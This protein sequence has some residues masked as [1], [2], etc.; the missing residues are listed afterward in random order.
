MVK[1]IGLLV[2]AIALLLTQLGEAIP[3]RPRVISNGRGS[4]ATVTIPT[5]LNMS[6]I[7][8]LG[9]VFGG[10]SN[11]L[12]VDTPVTTG[13]PFGSQT[14]FPA[15][16]SPTDT[17]W[18][19]P[20]IHE[21]TT[22]ATGG[23]LTNVE[24][25]V[26][27]A[28]TELH[29]LGGRSW[30]GHNRSCSGCSA[31]DIQKGSL[32]QNVY[33]YAYEANG[34]VRRAF[35]ARQTAGRPYLVA[36]NVLIH[37]EADDDA[38]LQAVYP[39]FLRQYQQDANNDSYLR[40]AQTFQVPLFVTQMNACSVG[41]GGAASSNAYMALQ[42][43]ANAYA[44]SGSYVMCGQRMHFG[45]QATSLY[46]ADGIHLSAQGQR[47]HGEALGL[48]L[49]SVLEA[50]VIFR[51]LLPSY[52]DVTATGIDVDYTGNIPCLNLNSTNT[53]TTAC[54]ASNCC[55]GAPLVL[56]TTI[57][58]LPWD[59]DQTNTPTY[60]F[61][62]ECPALTVRRPWITNVAISNSTHVAI[63]TNRPIPPGCTLSY[64]RYSVP[65]S[66]GG[67]GTTAN[68]F[69][70]ARG[71]LRDSMNI[72]G[73]L[74]GQRIYTIGP[75]WTAT[76]ASSGPDLSSI[77]TLL[78]DHD[79][80]Y[81]WD[82]PSGTSG[83]TLVNVTGASTY[84]LPA[85]AGRSWAASSPGAGIVPSTYG[86]ITPA[87]M[88]DALPGCW[89]Q[90]GL[91]ETKWNRN[92]TDDIWYR[93]VGRMERSAITTYLWWWQ[94]DAPT[95]NQMYV[96]MVG[97][98]GNLSFLYDGTSGGGAA[99][100]VVR[101]GL[102]SATPEWVVLDIYV[103]QHGSTNNGSV[104]TI[105]YQGNCSTSAA[106][107]MG[108]LT[109]GQLTVGMQSCNSSSFRGITIAHRFAFGEKARAQFS[110]AMHQREAALFCP[111]PPCT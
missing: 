108:D 57:Q 44:Y 102:I 98:N 64:A 4:L 28:I 66:Y 106:G 39:A 89:H 107:V 68:T 103:E 35:T 6:Q 65:G 32:S 56:D 77:N 2:A 41:F 29:A 67:N 62:L 91:G 69:G 90:T 14:R 72:T 84:D 97:A 7:E 75:T 15:Y 58:P 46:L 22:P 21:G 74:T 81:G 34:D 86:S 9:V 42:Q 5:P 92:T 26:T 8:G 110:V 99:Q 45:D 53:P 61:E 12:G 38:G 11:A 88:D 19:F 59:G 48:C 79:W 96:S 27:A 60:G 105:C 94:G 104:T 40:T 17:A 70:A 43:N 100:N 93:F 63:T 82:A 85:F 37:G 51:P 16:A 33:T 49:H 95:N 76:I 24:S 80:D 55:N 101:A 20:A 109:T 111:S 36:A 3:R 54:T 87:D 30:I 1:W 31:L 73:R 18:P 52:I 78:S 10:Q 23:N 47:L 71:N 83:T 25:A 13:A 50:G